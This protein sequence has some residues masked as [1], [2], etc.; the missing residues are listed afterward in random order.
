VYREALR[1]DADLYHFHDPEFLPYAVLLRLQGYD[2]I[3]DSHE[4][5]P[6]DVMGRTW[7]PPALR[8]PISRTFDL[9]ERWAARRF[10]AIVTAT[11]EIRQRHAEASVPAVTVYNFPI[12][13][14]LQS[15]DAEP[16]RERR[17]QVAYVGSL[18]EW[19]GIGEIVRAIDEVDVGFDPSLALAG[20]FTSPDFKQRVTAEDGWARVDFRGWCSREEV[21]DLL[22][23]SRCGLVVMHPTPSHMETMPV[24]LFEYMSVG[25][26]VIATD[27]PKWRDIIDGCGCGILVDP[28]DVDEIAEAIDWMFEHPEEAERMG[29]RGRQAVEETYRWSNEGSK[30]LALYDELLSV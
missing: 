20:K 7:I 4:D 2:V 1:C 13:E 12:Q 8:R 16:Y 11:P 15:D 5:V 24:K 19:R 26:P 27:L 21:S 17:N 10:T 29:Q 22:T 6:K 9:F 3:Y 28:Y 18:D 30:L 14:K 23:T 25:I